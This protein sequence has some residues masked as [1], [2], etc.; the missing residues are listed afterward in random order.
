VA[1]RMI[2]EQGHGTDLSYAELR[3][4]TNRF[5][6][7]LSGLGVGR[8]DKVFTLLGRTTE[9]YVT[10]LGALKN[11]SVVAPLFSA[12]GTDPVTQRLQLGDGRVLVTTSLQYKRKVAPRRHDFPA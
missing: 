7:V 4:L 2:D 6:N 10:V 12:F 9:L 3:R 1:L 5:A 11:G 8:G